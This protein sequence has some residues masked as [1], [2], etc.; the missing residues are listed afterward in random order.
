MF[1]LVLAHLGCPR[2]SPESRKTVV[3][4]CVCACVRA[5][6]CVDSKIGKGS[7]VRLWRVSELEID[8]LFCCFGID[9]FKADY[10]GPLTFLACC[11]AG[12]AGAIVMC[13]A[14]GGG[15][16]QQLSNRCLLLTTNNSESVACP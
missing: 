12:S 13:L 7:T 16:L 5:C 2:Q 10:L 15:Q 6:V 1:L 9:I 3:C 14:G 11:T 8:S 4:V